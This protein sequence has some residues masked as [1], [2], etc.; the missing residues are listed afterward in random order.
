MRGHGRAVDG[1]ASAWQP[2]ALGDIEDDAR[3][4]IRIEVNLLMVGDLAD[5]AFSSLVLTSVRARELT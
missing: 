2:D 3:E 1:W 4:A 5:G